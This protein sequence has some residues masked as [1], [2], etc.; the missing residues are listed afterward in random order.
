MFRVDFGQPAVHF[1]VWDGDGYRITRP[2][3]ER[4]DRREDGAIEFRHYMDDIFNGLIDAGLSI[5][6]VVDLSRSKRP[7]PQA[8][9]G[10]WTHESSYIGGNFVIVA[11]KE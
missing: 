3:F 2:Y 7:D 8:P 9:P 5:Q 4:T 1:M 10:S 6:Q 11:K